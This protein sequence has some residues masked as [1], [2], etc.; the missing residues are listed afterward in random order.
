MHHYLRHH[1]QFEACRGTMKTI[2][3]GCPFCLCL[4]TPKLIQG[5]WLKIHVLGGGFKY[6][7][8]NFT[9]KIGEDE[10]IFAN[11]FQMGWFNHQLDVSRSSL[12]ICVPACQLCLPL[13]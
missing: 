12:E 7:F 9:P 5:T 4:G 3:A 2:Y 1:D 8:G 11:I 10:P 6:I 13:R